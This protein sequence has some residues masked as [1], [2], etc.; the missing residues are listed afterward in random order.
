MHLRWYNVQ[1]HLGWHQQGNGRWFLALLRRERTCIRD[2]T[3]RH[4][5]VQLCG[6]LFEQFSPAFVLTGQQNILLTDLPS[7][8]VHH[9]E[10]MHLAEYGMSTVPAGWV[11]IAYA[12]ACPA[13]P[14]CGLALAEA[15]RAPPTVVQ[16]RS[17]PHLARPGHSRRTAQR[18]HDRLSQWLRSSLY[19]RYWHSW[20]HQGYLQHLCRW[21][22]AQHTSEYALCCLRTPEG[23]GR[24]SYVHC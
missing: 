20:T 18:A 15:E 8:S 12:M 22:L 4:R 2:D 21:R 14:T 10:A 16:A 19:G 9:I 11:H 24:Y 13:L 23:P 1:D 17:R 5:C 7:H 6:T 3:T